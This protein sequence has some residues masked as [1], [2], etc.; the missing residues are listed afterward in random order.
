MRSIKKNLLKAAETLF[1]HS[2][3][4]A[5]KAEQQLTLNETE[6]NDVVHTV[7]TQ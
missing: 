3:T 6:I 7:D 2:D 1:L 4:G 5:A